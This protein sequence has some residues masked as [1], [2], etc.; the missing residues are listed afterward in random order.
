M[1]GPVLSDAIY[2]EPLGIIGYRTAQ[3][4]LAA[5]GRLNR[6]D[7]RLRP[8]VQVSAL[9]TRAGPPQ[10]PPGVVAVTPGIERRPRRHWPPVPI[11]ST[12]TR[13]RWWRC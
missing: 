1:I 2:P 8:G 4:S 11:A 13:W 12:S 7:L 9:R 6:I 10:L 3:W 5:I